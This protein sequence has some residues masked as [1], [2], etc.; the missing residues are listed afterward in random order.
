MKKNDITWL[1]G[2]PYE[3]HSMNET[4][5]GG[6]KSEGWSYISNFSGN[7]LL[8]DR[9]FIFEMYNE[10]NEREFLIN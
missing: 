3:E 1:C 8:G 7:I 5:I 9:P 10:K 2:G 4:W 6:L